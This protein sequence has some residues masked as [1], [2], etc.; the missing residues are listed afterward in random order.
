YKDI[1][2]HK[3]K[4]ECDFVVLKD[5]SVISAIQVCMTLDADNRSR[6]INGL[7]EAL[8]AYNLEEGYIVTMD[9]TDFFEIDG[10]MIKVV[11]ISEFLS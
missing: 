6:E 5:D 8:I 3:G 2:Y 7:L 11:P 9:Q 1:C 4:G 10:K